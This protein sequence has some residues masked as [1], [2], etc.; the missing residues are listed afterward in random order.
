MKKFIIY[1]AIGLFVALWALYFNQFHLNKTDKATLTNTLVQQA[2]ADNFQVVWAN[3]DIWYKKLP[4]NSPYIDINLSSDINLASINENSFEISPKVKWNVSL[5]SWST[6]R[7]TLNEPLKAWESYN[8]LLSKDIKNNKWKALDKEYQYDIKAIDSVKVVKVTPEWQID[9]LSQNI[10]VFFN[11]PMVSLSS[12]ES[13]ENYDCP[14]EISPKI[15]WICKWTT[16]SVLEF[17]PSKPLAW[18]TSYKITVTNKPWLLFSLPQDYLSNFSTSPLTVKI[19]SSNNLIT[20]DYDGN[21][22]IEPDNKFYASL[23]EQ[24]SFNYPIDLEKI[25]DKIHV[26]EYS[27]NS[28]LFNSESKFWTSD[29]FPKDFVVYHTNSWVDLLWNDKNKLQSKVEIDII[30]IKVPN[31]DS[32]TDFIIKPK[33]SNFDFNTWYIF[34]VDA[35]IEPK[36]WNIK[37]KQWTVQVLTSYDFINNIEVFRKVYSATWELIDTIFFADKYIPNDVFFNINFEQKIKLNSSDFELSSSGQLVDIEVAYAKKIV[38]KLDSAWNKIIDS[39]GSVVTEQVDDQTKIKLSPKAKLENDKI[40]NL[41]VKKNMK[42]IDDTGFTLDKDIQNNFT[43]SPNLELKQ[44]KFIS[45]NKSCLTFNNEISQ[46]NKLQYMD[47]K[48]SKFNKIIIEPKARIAS[49][50]SEI[51]LDWKKTT[52]WDALSLNTR[53]NPNSKYK[54]TI[55]KDLED[56]YWNKL[57]KDISN[58][59]VTKSLSPID[60]YIYSS[61]NK[62][63]NVIPSNLPIIID[64]QSINLDKVDVEICQMNVEGYNDYITNWYTGKKPNCVKSDIKNLKLVNHA[65]N[66]TDNQFDIEKDI[67]QAKLSENF[68]LVRSSLNWKYIRDYNQPWK[69][70]QNLYIRTNLFLGIEQ[71]A[72]TN[73]I[74]ATSLNGSKVIKWLNFRSINYDQSSQSLKTTFDDQKQ[75]YKFNKIDSVKII[76]ASSKE[77]FWI[78]D[79]N[80]DYLSNYDFGYL[81][82]EGSSEQN[83]AYIYTDRPMYKPW[84][85][86]YIKWLVRKFNLNWYWKSNLTGWTLAIINNADFNRISSNDITIDNNSNF[87]TEF[88][89]P[90]DIPLWS[91]SFEISD[92]QDNNYKVN[93]NWFNIQEYKKPVFKVNIEPKSSDSLAWDYANF[94]IMPEYYFGWKMINTSWNYSILTQ[95]YFFDAKE[96]SDY[97]FWIGYDYF[98]CLY[99]DNCNYNDNL[100]NY[101]PFQVNE[102]WEYSLSYKIPEGE[103]EKIYSFSFE[104]KDPDTNLTVSNDSSVI[105]HNTDAYTW[106]KTDYFNTKTDWIKVK[107]VL[108]DYQAKPKSG[109]IGLTLIKREWQTAKKQDVDWVFYN[110][111]SLKEQSESNIELSTS[112]WWQITHTFVPKSDW[113]Y[114]VRATY[115]WSNLKSFVSSSIIYVSWN[116]YVEWRKSNNDLTDLVADKQIMNVWDSQTFVLKSPVNNWK[117]L[118]IYEKDDWIL[119]YYIHDIKSYWDKII[120]KISNEYYP[121]FYTK[122]LLIWS[123]DGNP[124]PIYKRALAVTKVNTDYKKLSINLQTDKKFYKPWEKIKLDIEVRDAKWNPVNN[125]NWSIAIVDESLL[126]LAWNPKQNPF[127]FFYDMKRYLWTISYSSLKD[128]I[129]KLE[130]KDMTHWEKWGDWDDLKW[131]NSNRKRWLFKDTAFWKSNFQT[132]A[133]WKFSILTD[134]LPDN[135]TTWNIEVLVNTTNDN[136]IW[137]ANETIITNKSVMISDNLPRFFWSSDNLVI[138]PVVYNKTDH[139]TIFIVTITWSNLVFDNISKTISI[140]KWD[141]QIVDFNVKVPSTEWYATV[142]ISANSWWNSDTVT[143]SIPIL[144]RA[145]YEY[146]S[147]SWKT[148]WS[149][150]AEKIDVKDIMSNNN[151]LKINYSVTALSNLTVWIDY[152]NYYPYKC[153]EQSTSTVMS[154]IY[155]KEL[156]DSAQIDFDL[157]KKIIKYS[158]EDWEHQISVEQSIKDYLV[159]IFSFQKPNWWFVYWPN[160]INSE[161][162][163]S[164]YDLTSMIVESIWR[165]KQL[166]FSVNDD[167]LI[168]AIKYLKDRFYLNSFENCT[169]KNKDACKYPEIQRLNAI[170]AILSYNGNDYEAYKMWKL[171]NLE[172]IPV[173]SQS[174]A[175]WKLLNLK[176]LG[177]TDK[178]N[179]T[180]YAITNINKVLSEQLTF[181]QRW[182]F[183][184]KT[185]SYSRLID[186]ANLLEALSVIWL[187]NFNDMKS[188]TSNILR[189]IINQKSN[190]SFGSTQDNIQVIKAITKYLQDSWELKDIKLNA[191]IKLNNWVI[192][193]RQFNSSN[194]LETYSKLVDFNQLKEVNDFVID[195]TGSWNLYYDLNLKYI[196]PFEDVQARDEWFSIVSTYFNYNDYIKIKSHKEQEWKAYTENKV[197]YSDLKYTKPI[198]EYLTP[199]KEWK[200][201]E[202]VL[203]FNKIITPEPRDKVAFELYIPW[204]SELVNVNLKTES[205]SSKSIANEQTLFD[206]TEYRNDRLFGFTNSLDT[207]EYKYFYLIRLTHAWEFTIKPSI[208]SEMYNQEIFWRTQE[209]RFSITH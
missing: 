139:D 173:A 57:G 156:F 104:V 198:E 204:W 90:K 130:L 158:D 45:Y 77:Y 72:N 141:K 30:P 38:D 50:E 18:S 111:Y 3:F 171:L 78:I 39:T 101:L 53:L 106:I 167:K 10:A 108:L 75:V 100:K 150:T 126:A 44:F 83:F 159:N 109:L 140:N 9:N 144:S 153:A 16:T 133:N 65:W 176:D 64:I 142:E 63:I 185:L 138:A 207:W 56:I 206:N 13:K 37:L 15:D 102:N 125:A 93:T 4:S 40:Y 76:E 152:L 41:V 195:T 112:T 181:N 120:T 54:I 129:E 162:T 43:T 11:I 115:T 119:D 194:K 124:L 84:D 146:V 137:T 184:W 177:A 149:H 23:G 191:D 175:I 29:N 68:V 118:I 148:D 135:L 17:T 98:N 6:I 132:D 193:T 97:N 82:W 80:K 26:Y 52:C 28:S 107:A 179:L 60:K 189:W 136:L 31:G 8:I 121:N 169:N 209:R 199:I 81:L 61:L 34:I 19:I 122:V 202:L 154:N 190:W 12:L 172:T 110:D 55:S 131:W 85:T 197:A 62:D 186:T 103:W 157:K 66:Y 71:A 151:T 36:Y 183:I 187:D 174:L 127:A 24:I 117:A 58:E 20:Y 113:E 88:V 205:Q 32:E 89:L 94:K 201:W 27:S 161:S 196:L 182:A 67:L 59:V 22:E 178:D 96:F 51:S 165:I 155:L 14:I 2:N 164:D 163:Y 21:E 203:V 7:Y 143:K 105:V 128:L 73:L 200:V 123:Q 35:W 170:K 188:I 70:F 42:I 92:N 192:D 79:L 134:S 208:V 180:N 147:T 114:E 69:S 168:V 87:E 25:K 91:F 46:E 5:Y 99:W 145:T 48:E 49:F 47:P 33:G 1:W 74:F 86:I 95:N 160:M 166:W 116:T